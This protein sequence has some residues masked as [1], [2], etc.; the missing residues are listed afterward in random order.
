MSKYPQIAKS[1]TLDVP[2]I[3]TSPTHEA[4]DG[5]HTSE[6][7]LPTNTNK[8]KLDKALSLDSH[9]DQ[10]QN[11]NSVSSSM[12]SMNNTS[13]N[14][15]NNS[16]HQ[17]QFYRQQFLTPPPAVYFNTNNVENINADFKINQS[18]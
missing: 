2:I 5:N 17:F 9:C 12:S 10:K 7:L 6:I 13:E 18:D 4:N 16:I 15:S 1:K 11:Q 3:I 14:S 8:Y